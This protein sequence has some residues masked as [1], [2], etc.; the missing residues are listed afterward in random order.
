MLSGAARATEPDLRSELAN[1]SKL[2]ADSYS[3]GEGGI[4]T[5]GKGLSPYT[6]LAGEPVQPLRHLPV[7]NCRS[8][9]EQRAEGEGFEP[10]V[11]FATLVFKTSALNHSAIPPSAKGF[12]H[13]TPRRASTRL[14]RRAGS[15]VINGLNIPQQRAGGWVCLQSAQVRAG[16]R[17][18]DVVEQRYAG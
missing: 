4:R 3:G 15:S 14:R 9:Q 8:P 18:F 7:F 13:T 10:T 5:L 11:T 1:R 6:H 16:S 2:T 12:Y 17:C